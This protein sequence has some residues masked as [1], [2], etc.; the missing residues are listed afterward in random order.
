M[1]RHDGDLF[2][3]LLYCNN[4]F[5]SDEE[6]GES[7]FSAVGKTKE[8]IPKDWEPT[9]FNQPPLNKE[10]KSNFDEEPGDINANSDSC[11]AVSSNSEEGR[12]SK[13]VSKSDHSKS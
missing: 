9:N 3:G 10:G 5:N 11:S 6:E 12:S 1:E 2:N 7:E 13:S 4:E 8:K